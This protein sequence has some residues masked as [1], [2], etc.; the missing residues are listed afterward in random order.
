MIETFIKRDGTSEPYMAK[1]ANGWGEWSART[2]GDLV[3]WP[4]AVMHTAGALPAV[5]TTKDFQHSLIRYCL[6]QN[7]WA[8]HRMAGKLYA[9]THHKDLYPKDQ[10][11]SIQVLHQRL[12][13][14]GY[15]VPL[16]YSDAEYAMLDD[17]IDHER[18][19]E[20]AHSQIHQ[21]RYKY[22]LR[23]QITKEEFE[24]CQFVFMRMAMALGEDQPKDRRI[25]DVIH[26]YNFFSQN[27][28]NAPTPNYTNLGTKLNGYASC[29]LIKSGDS[30]ESL[31]IGDHIAYMMTVM[32]AGIG[33]NVDTR[34]IGDPVRGGLFPHRGKLWYYRSLQGAIQANIKNGRN[35]A[36]NVFFGAFDP[37]N[38]DI[39]RLKNPMTPADMQI[40]GMD[41]AMLAN[42]WLGRKAARNQDVF[43]FNC[44]TAPDLADAF[45]S[46]NLLNFIALYEK[47]EADDKFKKVY[48]SAR[49]LLLQNGNE[50]F[51]TGR[52]YF[53]DIEEINRHTAY[54]DRINSSNLCVAPETMLLTDLGHLEIQSIEGKTVN[55]W[56]G[57]EFSETTVVKTGSNQKLLTVNL[58]DGRRLECTPYHK[59]YVQDSYHGPAVEVRAADLD[60]GQKL[61]K[62][63]LPVIEGQVR[64]D[65]P[66]TNGFYTGDGTQL[67]NGQA[68]L[69]LYG[70]KKELAGVID[71]EQE[72]IWRENG[73]RMETE[74]RGLQGKFFVPMSDYTV[75]SR[76][77]WLAG[78]LDADGCVHR[79]GENEAITGASTNLA[80]LEQL[81]YMLQTLG[82]NAKISLL[83][84]AGPQRLPMNDGSGRSQEYDCKAVYRLLLTSGDT[85]RLLQ[86]GLN[87]R[88]LSIQPRQ[89]Q[90]DASQFVVVVGVFDT[91]RVSDT[92][93]VTE[94]KRHMAV[95]NGILTGQCMEIT[96]PTEEYT[97]MRDLY[98]DGPI[99]HIQLVD[100]NK[101]VRRYEAA[102]PIK[103]KNGIWDA[104]QNLKPGD[105]Y[106]VD[107][108]GVESLVQVAKI[109]SLK[110]ESEVALCSLAGIVLPNIKSP[111]EYELAMYYALLMID[112]CI[113]KSEYKLPH[114]G[115]TAKARMSAGVGIMSL[116]HHMA[117]KGLKYSNKEGLE[118]MHRVAETHM[119]YAIKASLKLG[120]ELGN[121]PW[122]HRT[123]WID[124]WTPMKTYNRNVDELGN[125]VNQYDW[126]A[127]SDEIKANGGIRNSSLVSYMPGESSSKASGGFNSIYPARDVWLMKTDGANS[128]YW[129]APDSDTLTYEL[130]WDIPLE[131][132]FKGYAVFQKW[133][134]MSISA[135]GFVKLE[136]S[137]KVTSDEMLEHYFTMF[138]YGVKT[139]YYMNVK[140]AKAV[141]L[142]RPET[143]GRQLLSEAP[144]DFTK[145][146]EPL[147]GATG[148]EEML[149]HVG[150][151]Q[152][153][154]FL[155][156][157]ANGGVVHDGQALMS[158]SSFNAVSSNAVVQ[159]ESM[160]D[161][162]ARQARAA[163]ADPNNAVKPTEEFEYNNEG[164]R[165]CGPGGCSL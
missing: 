71:A 130:A 32:S 2:L 114:L 122:I 156:A 95:F 14:V 150:G 22:A 46:G 131:W 111:E 60:V 61:I 51:E 136:G 116:A 17:I 43:L 152:P 106:F 142:D 101:E 98:T 148:N 11:P 149:A 124:G 6:S 13:D 30:A 7:T 85:Q 118:E 4:S 54:K 21:I 155:Y 31:A 52:G 39:L 134:D 24:T 62:M 133:T 94:P 109:K 3:D 18:D 42:K 102:W 158:V 20:Y 117:R 97:D 72:L 100:T 33:I 10:V 70:E 25:N 89:V 69:Y 41:Y 67:P 140:T 27:K 65:R 44:F 157:A 36:C 53:A 147:V 8:W 47:Y 145:R 45:Y 108:D 50:A 146:P 15:M 88:R 73:S 143:D 132:Q 84:P 165:G 58:S 26:W 93:C 28:I 81:Q 160:M 107:H 161:R 37:E 127:L 163:V 78:W 77:N 128:I 99:G 19:F 159:G 91:G 105:E 137:Q 9:T 138:K 87:T 123:K 76:L 90:R 35:G 68:K 164:E 135:D 92:Y 63:S 115:Y 112:K 79:N 153:G 144:T 120:K 55:V 34:S 1:K 23:N 113:H 38:R 56:N 126:N 80:F 48:V 104:A 49:E 121:A 64:L 66:Y 5:C 29:C 139:R 83:T 16:D 74:T 125:F 12:V 141:V 59:F 162:I 119:Y 82:T 96:E 75:E 110:K 40:R 151:V 154:F 86:L 103:F 129:A 57:E